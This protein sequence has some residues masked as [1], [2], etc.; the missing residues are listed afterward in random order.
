MINSPPE[1]PVE[2]VKDI[3]KQHM[4]NKKRLHEIRDG[5]SD[6]G[7]LRGR[8]GDCGQGTGREQKPGQRSRGPGPSSGRPPSEPTQFPTDR[9]PRPNDGP[10]YRPDYGPGCEPGYEPDYGNGPGTPQFMRNGSRLDLLPRMP[11]ISTYM[12]WL[13]RKTTHPDKP[14]ARKSWKVVLRRYLGLSK[15][16]LYLQVTAQ[17]AKNARKR[18]SLIDVYESLNSRYQRRQIDRLISDQNKKI[19]AYN[20]WLEFKLARIET[21]S[22]RVGRSR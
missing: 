2:I 16:D 1:K 9:G 21:K 8:D 12:G 3:M 19:Q 13:L 15:E 5:H 20:P 7:S 10:D 11:H 14:L 6:A 17:M 4:A 18:R 22:K